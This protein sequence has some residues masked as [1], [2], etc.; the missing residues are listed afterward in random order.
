MPARA[1]PNGK[2]R[3]RG[4]SCSTALE[5]GDDADAYEGHEHCDRPVPAM[6][7]PRFSPRL[8]DQRLNEGLDLLSVERLVVARRAR[9]R[10][11]TRRSG[12]LHACLPFTIELV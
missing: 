6:A 2:P 10:R 3:R 4:L 1:H 11:R 9:R 12:N 7:T 5:Q 8:L